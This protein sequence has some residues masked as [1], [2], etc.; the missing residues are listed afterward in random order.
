MNPHSW[1]WDAWV[2]FG[3]AG[4]LCFTLRFIV[5]WVSSEKRKESFIPVY[6]WYFSLAGG[7]VLSFYAWHRRDPVFLLGQSAGLIVYIRNLMLIRNQ[8]VAVQPVTPDQG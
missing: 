2:V 8:K 6:F 3:Y 1:N 4:Q 5:Q 7:L